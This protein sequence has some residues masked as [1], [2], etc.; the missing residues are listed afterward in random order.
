M[1]PAL[2]VGGSTGRSFMGS[3]VPDVGEHTDP[4]GVAGCV[5]GPRPGPRPRPTPRPGQLSAGCSSGPFAVPG[6]GEMAAHGGGAETTTIGDEGGPPRGQWSRMGRG[7]RCP[8]PCGWSRSSDA[9][10]PGES[11]SDGH[12]EPRRMGREGGAGSWPPGPRV[13]PVGGGNE[14][15]SRPR[16]LADLRPPPGQAAAVHPAPRLCLT[17]GRFPGGRWV[18]TH[19]DSML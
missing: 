16:A 18:G 10:A 9:E 2:R 1:V 5:G 14:H 11:Q 6:Q 12:G 3:K 4:H 7:G 13:S 8:T 17:G 19:L 15:G